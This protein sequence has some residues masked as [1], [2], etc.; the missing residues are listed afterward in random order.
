M[1]KYQKDKIYLK[2]IIKNYLSFSI[3]YFYD[4]YDFDIEIPNNFNFENM[5]K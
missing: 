1:K 5:L 3:H 4:N 2:E